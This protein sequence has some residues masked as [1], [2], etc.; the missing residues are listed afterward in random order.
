MKEGKISFWGCEKNIF[1]KEVVH[2]P[3]GGTPTGEK[4]VYLLFM[5]A[6]CSN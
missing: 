6:T 2:V 5:K 1:S 4:K 3:V